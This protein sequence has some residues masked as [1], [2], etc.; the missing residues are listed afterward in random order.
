MQTFAP[1]EAQTGPARRNDVLSMQNH[2]ELLKN[3][4]H[5]ALYKLLSDA[6]KEVYEEKL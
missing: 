3:E 1:R 4:K 5:I 2:L 6:I